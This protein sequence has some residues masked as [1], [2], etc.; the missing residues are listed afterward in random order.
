MLQRSCRSPEEERIDA[1]LVLTGNLTQRSRQRKGHQKVGPGQQQ[2]L[3]LREPGLRGILLTGGTVPIATRVIAV[4]RRG[5]REA[6]E[7]MAAQGFRATLLNRDHG[8][9]MAREHPGAEL[10]AIGGPIASEDVGNGYPMTCS[11]TRLM[12][13]VARSSAR[14]VR[15]V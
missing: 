15:C 10:L 2:V 3:L 5:T 4:A 11:I 7:D 1:A 13:S 8:G 9:P 6:G 12:A 14:R